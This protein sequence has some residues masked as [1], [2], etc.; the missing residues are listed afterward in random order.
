MSNNP[1][2][3]SV[4]FLYDNKF[5]CLIVPRF[6]NFLRHIIFHLNFHVVTLFTF[7]ILNSS[8]G[9]GTA[10]KQVLFS[11]LSFLSPLSRKS[12]PL[13][14]KQK[15][16]KAAFAIQNFSS[17]KCFCFLNCFEWSFIFFH[18]IVQCFWQIFIRLG[19]IKRVFKFV[20]MWKLLLQSSSSS[21]FFL[22]DFQL[23]L[24]PQVALESG[25]N[26]IKYEERLI[27]AKNTLIDW[28]LCCFYLDNFFCWFSF[29]LIL[30]YFLSSHSEKQL[31]FLGKEKK[32]SLSI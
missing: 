31:H 8:R 5:K 16:R 12:I 15:K 14:Q 21:T 19:K 29:L 18:K 6:S 26:P 23:K 24:L 10:F 7:A 30:S 25:G 27:F 17:F 13:S 9:H 3:I 1:T 28:L 32:I 2:N 20:I 11:R 22:F 4:F